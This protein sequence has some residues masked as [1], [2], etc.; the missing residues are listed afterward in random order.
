MTLMTLLQ[1]KAYARANGIPTEKQD[2]DRS[3]IQYW[4]YMSCENPAGGCISNV[5]SFTDPV[6]ILFSFPYIF[7]F[8]N[9]LVLSFAL[10]NLWKSFLWL[11]RQ[12]EQAK[13]L[14]KASAIVLTLVNIIALISD[15]SILVQDGKAQCL[16]GLVCIVLPTKTLVILIL[17]LPVACFST[18]ILNDANQPNTRCQR[19][20]YALALCQRFAH[21]LALC[22]IVW[23]IHR[24]VNDVI[25]SVAFF[26]IAPAQ[27]LGIDA[28][29]LA[30]IGSAIAFVA[31][32]I[33][34]WSRFG[35]CNKWL[36][37]FV[38]CAAFNGLVVS[39]LL[40]IITW[41][42]LIFVNNGLKSSGMGGL[43]LSL[44]PPLAVTVIGYIVKEKYF[45]SSSSSE[46]ENE[47][48][49]EVNGTTTIQNVNDE[50]QDPQ[51]A[52]PLLHSQS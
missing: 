43:I 32:I 11:Q 2:T 24:L 47:L 36:C 18:N 35:G 33:H 22:Q 40:F 51:E 29:F 31:I 26:V 12:G 17:E 15:I 27:T 5:T 48:P 42:F 28:L 25:I 14:Y 39:G 8:S 10:L 3:I 19:F 50:E 4:L 52:T 49:Q 45:K 1:A 46:S 9:V 20:A 38:L 6:Y 30:T 13:I 44:I 41:V 21:A 16:D 7:I 37:C 23:F 34:K